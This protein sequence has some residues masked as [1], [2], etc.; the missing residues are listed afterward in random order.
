MRYRDKIYSSYYTHRQLLAADL[1]SIESVTI[2]YKKE[3]LKILPS[4]RDI[5]ILDL[6]CGLGYFLY[7]L[8]KAG[9]KNITGVDLGEEQLR[10]SQKLGVRD[11]VIQDDVFSFLKNKDKIYDVICA[12]DLLEHFHK[13]EL[14]DLLDLIY[15][16][17]TLGGMF[18][19]RVPNGEALFPGRIRY[20]DLTHELSFTRNSLA[21]ALTVVGFNHYQFYPV[22][23]V[24]HGIKSL[25]R[26]II[27]EIFEKLLW[28]Y[29]VAETGGVRGYIITQNFWGWAKKYEKHKTQDF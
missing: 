12:F 17:L 27:F 4:D 11:F 7:V 9:Y 22:K 2:W 10:V 23:P 24:I 13:D 8:K 15:S 21:Q 18:I 25:A 16:R 29:L 1:D 6:G 14:L 3:V 5:K 19:F 26:R 20:G 28:L